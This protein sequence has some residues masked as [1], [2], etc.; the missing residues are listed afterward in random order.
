MGRIDGAWGARMGVV[1]EKRQQLA[2]GIGQ[3]EWHAKRRPPQEGNGHVVP[4]GARDTQLQHPHRTKCLGC[5]GL[6]WK[7]RNCATRDVREIESSKVCVACKG[8]RMMVTKAILV[9]VDPRPNYMSDKIQTLTKPLH[10]VKVDLQ[11]FFNRDRLAGGNRRK[12]RGVQWR[13]VRV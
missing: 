12:N 11:P 2:V 7:S 10:G 5:P 4:L 13:L 1:E 6:Y 8:W 9:V 3:H